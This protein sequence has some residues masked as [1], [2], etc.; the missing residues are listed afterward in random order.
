MQIIGHRLGI[1]VL[2]EIS[3]VIPKYL[4]SA[5][6][7]TCNSFTN[8]YPTVNCSFL[9]TYLLSNAYLWLSY[10]S[11]RENKGIWCNHLAVLT[12]SSSFLCLHIISSHDHCTSV[13]PAHS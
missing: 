2:K 7:F 8:N 3:Q 10:P 4:K 5:Q 9:A 13:F 6:S 11:S 1:S 12:E